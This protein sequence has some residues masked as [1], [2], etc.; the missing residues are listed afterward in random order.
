VISINLAGVATFLLQGVSPRSWWDAKRSKRMT[1]RALV[2]W[3]ALLVIVTAL[4]Y[5]SKEL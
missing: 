4:I 5:L 1:R 3:I 2:I